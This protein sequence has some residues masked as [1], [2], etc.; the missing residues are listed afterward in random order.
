MK[1]IPSGVYEVNDAMVYDL[2]D[3]PLKEH[4][5]NLGALIARDIARSIPNAKSFIADPVV[6]DELADVARMSGHPLFKRESIFHAL[7]QKAIARQHAQSVGKKYEEMNLIVVHM[8][9]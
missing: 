7:N 2:Q 5:S 4:A 3:K 9:G 8:G 6:V 1:P